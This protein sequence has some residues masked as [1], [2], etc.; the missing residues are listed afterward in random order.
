MSKD[1]N[2]YT[3]DLD[4]LGNRRTNDINHGIMRDILNE[5]GP[6]FCLAKWK[7]VTM[8]LGTGMTH[9]CHHPSTHKIP[10]EELAEN[11]TALHNTN[12]K[13]AQRTAMLN[14]ERPSECDYCWRIEDTDALS[15][16]ASKSMEHWA[17][18]SLQDIEQLKGEEDIVPTYLEVSFSNACNMKCLYCGPDA[19]SKW[20]DEIKQNG[21][22]KLLEGTNVEHWAQGWQEDLKV[23]AHRDDNPYVN[24]FWEWWPELYKELRVF[25]I[26]GGE[27]LM[28]KDTFRVLEWF[29]EHPNPELE[30]SINS[31][32]SVPDKVWDKFIEYIEKLK[33]SD[34]IKNIT[35]Y[36]SVEAWGKR[37]EYIRTGLDFNKFKARYEQL[38]A[39]PN[40]RA[41]IMSTFN[42]L[43]VTS[44]HLLLEWQLELREKY[45]YNPSLELAGKEYNDMVTS[46]GFKTA[47]LDP[48]P[49][50][51][52]GDQVPV[53]IDIP[54][55]RYPPFLDV[56]NSTH[57]LVEEFLLPTLEYMMVNESKQPWTMNQGFEK[58]EIAKLRRIV[59]HRLYYNQN[60]KEDGKPDWHNRK[61]L[62]AARAQFYEFTKEMDARNGTDFLTTFPEMQEFYNE[63]KES[64][65]RLYSGVHGDIYEQEVTSETE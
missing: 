8:H 19:S 57:Q 22:I 9:S 10:L 44:F 20:V 17:L 45:N 53:C 6:G 43:S 16:R 35:I 61:D 47:L 25:R 24:A 64:I 49:S 3:W 14:G 52:H 36:T 50:W 11:K 21:P 37:A 2:E 12:F 13:K 65:K 40:M 51:K 18:N 59:Y 27:P 4:T 58:H 32:L 30:L 26:T 54:Y 38:V 62:D 1:I 23:Y 39:M 48:N 29:L 34:N 42:I 56:R 7:Q 46:L 60:N 63:C 33:D 55:L 41:V 28:S 15:D 31:N 5:T